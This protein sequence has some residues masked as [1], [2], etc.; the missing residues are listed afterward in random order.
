MN[1]TDGVY[2]RKTA[3]IFTVLFIWC[4]AGLAAN[5]PKLVFENLK[6]DLGKVDP[7]SKVEVTFPFH[8]AG[9]AVLEIFSVKPG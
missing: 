7:G 5:G 3:F 8:N 2:M 9:N 1:L 6:V 4:A